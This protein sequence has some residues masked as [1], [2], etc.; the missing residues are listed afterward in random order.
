MACIL[1][2]MGAASSEEDEKDAA[3]K[4]LARRLSKERR[5]SS[6][7][8]AVFALDAPRKPTSCV[9]TRVLNP[10]AFVEEVRRLNADFRN[11][12]ELVSLQE[13]GFGITRG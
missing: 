1:E 7:G 4:R 13:E 9:S 6:L 2:A 5:S 11:N 12:E 10:A 3:S 8:A